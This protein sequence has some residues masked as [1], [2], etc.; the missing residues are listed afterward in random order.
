MTPAGA[1]N[2]TDKKLVMDVLAFTDSLTAEWRAT[3]A[4]P[5]T[6]SLRRLA[7]PACNDL[8]PPPVSFQFLFV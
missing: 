5:P 2:L 8:D 6:E 1:K 7:G 3:V 4:M